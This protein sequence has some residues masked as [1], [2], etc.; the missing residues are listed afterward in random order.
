MLTDMDW[1]EAPGMSAAEWRDTVGG[2][3]LSG[4]VWEDA[5]ADGDRDLGE[6]GIEGVRVWLDGNPANGVWDEA[7]SSAVTESDGSWQLTGILP[8]TYEVRRELEGGWT[9]TSPAEGFQT[10]DVGVDSTHEG[11]D[12]GSACS[13]QE[14]CSPVPDQH[15]YTETFINDQMF[16]RSYSDIP[17]W[18]TFEKTDIPS[19]D[20]LCG[21]GGYQSTDGNINENEND[22]IIRATVSHSEEYVRYSIDFISEAFNESWDRVDLV[23][24]SRDLVSDNTPDPDKPFVV[25]FFDDLGDDFDYQTDFDTENYHC[26]LFEYAAYGGMINANKRRHIM[27]AR[28]YEN[29]ET[30]HWHMRGEFRSRNRE[31]ENWSMR[32]L[33]SD[34]DLV[35][36]WFGEAGKPMVTRRLVDIPRLVPHDTGFPKDEWACFIDGLEIYD[37][38]IN[39]NSGTEDRIIQAYMQEGATNWEAVVS[40]KTHGSDGDKENWNVDILCHRKGVPTVDGSVGVSAMPVL[41]PGYFVGLSAEWAPYPDAAEY[42]VTR[43]WEDS[44]GSESI[45]ETTSATEAVTS[46]VL[47]CG[48]P[49]TCMEHAITVEA[50]SENGILL[51]TGTDSFCEIGFSDVP[52]APEDLVVSGEDRAL[53]LS[54]SEPSLDGGAPVTLYEYEI[55]GVYD[56]VFISETTTG[57][58]ATEGGLQNGNLYEVRVRAQNEHG[59]GAWTDY[60]EGT[61][62]VALSVTSTP[63]FEPGFFV[64]NRA[65][66]TAVS[67]ATSYRVT[68]YREDACGS[69][70]DTTTTTNTRSS[71]GLHGNCGAPEHC[72][73]M[74]ATV[75]ALN[76]GN[77][78]IAVGSDEFCEVG[79]PA[80]GPPEAPTDV[81]VTRR[82]GA[83]DFSWLAPLDDGASPITSYEYQVEPVGGGSILSGTSATTSASQGGLQNG[84]AY[85]VRV[86]AGNIHG[87]GP[88]SADVAGTP[89]GVV[90]VSAA[91]DLE[92]GY[93]IGLTA[94]WPAY[95]GAT[96]YRVTHSYS[97]SCA[98]GSEEE[99]TSATS[100]SSSLVF[101]CDA[102][103]LCLT[104]EAKV[105][106]YNAVGTL[107]AEG[108]TSFCEVGDAGSTL[109]GAPTNLVVTPGDGSLSFSWNEPARYRQRADP[110]ATNTRSSPRTK[111]GTPALRAYDRGDPGRSAERSDLLRARPRPE[112]GRLRTLDPRGSGDPPGTALTVTST[113]YYQP[114]YLVGNRATWSAVTGATQLPGDPRPRGRLRFG[115][116]RR[117]H[118]QHPQ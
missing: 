81:T 109:P 85:N 72:Y 26:G 34:R 60:V 112:Q 70:E 39:E 4:T 84:T 43:S 8:G 80:P 104:R 114:G 78:V 46:T 38:D 6:N 99:T 102:P 57:S 71:S 106:A 12:L 64:G 73:L 67:G 62:Q 28:A 51:A 91:P 37:G 31:P 15:P 63:Y 32:L 89:I 42:R 9:V 17:S 116:Q 75:E 98:S 44:C 108:T 47:N 48:A 53:S 95:S 14:L 35:A 10:V 36:N 103:E 100:S 25:Q 83:L 16:I 33:C 86:R 29:A 41:E 68:H 56:S 18:T 82:D 117:H 76:S 1:L 52:A 24:L 87:F 66:W 65:T 13:N 5:N 11:L 40:F 21:I 20:W 94:N 115:H 3:I 22:T 58:S 7:E 96:S 49:D 110:V 111:P 101:N 92:P 118:H 69:Q 88:W 113:P 105:E 54:W 79:D 77:A 19:A 61:P 107:L 74:R 45:T 23:C 30:G 27:V 93:M 50:Y 90:S 59:W 2:A 97:S 55:S